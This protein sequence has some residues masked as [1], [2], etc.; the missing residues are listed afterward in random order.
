MSGS[1]ST[2][3]PLVG[4]LGQ[5]FDAPPVGRLAHGLRP[6]SSR[7]EHLNR[8]SPSNGPELVEGHVRGLLSAASIRRHLYTG[9]STD[10]AQRLTD[11]ASGRACRTTTLDAP[12]ALL[13]V[14]VFATF[15]EARRREAQIKRWSRAKK[16]ALIRGDEANLK[17]LAR[18][19]DRCG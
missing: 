10:L 18:S 4:L 5:P 14:E 17:T 2:R 19:R 12:V 6:A 15:P 16:E 11:H 1:H 13:R 3:L 7:H 9:A 8:R